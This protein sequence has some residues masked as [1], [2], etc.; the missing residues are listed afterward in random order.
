MRNLEI[1]DWKIVI[2]FHWP[3]HRFALGWDFINPNKEFNYTTI[4]LYL[5]IATVTI[6]F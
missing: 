5:L 1:V 6:D 4:N 2:A 3:H